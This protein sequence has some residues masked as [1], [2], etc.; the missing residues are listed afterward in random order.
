MCSYCNEDHFYE[1]HTYGACGHSYVICSTCVESGFDLCPKHGRVCPECRGS[2]RG[3]S[4]AP[5]VLCQKE[6]KSSSIGQEILLVQPCAFCLRSFVQRKVLDGDCGH[7]YTICAQCLESEYNGCGT[8]RHHVCATCRGGQ[9][10]HPSVPCRTCGKQQQHQTISIT[11]S[12]DMQVVP[13]ELPVPQLTIQ[14][15]FL[16]PHITG[17][18]ATLSPP[19][20]R[21]GVV[22]WNVAHFSKDPINLYDRYVKARDC[23]QELYDYAVQNLEK[24]RVQA[25]AE[26]REWKLKIELLKPKL[27]SAYETK[28]RV[29]A[30]VKE[31]APPST[32]KGQKDTPEVTRYKKKFAS[33]KKEAKTAK[34]QFNAIGLA[35]IRNWL[36]M[37]ETLSKAQV[38]DQFEFGLVDF[39]HGW[40]PA[41]RT[42]GSARTMFREKRVELA[43]DISELRTPVGRL[44]MT[45]RWREFR[46]CMDTAGRKVEADS[47]FDGRPELLRVKEL[48]ATANAAVEALDRAMHKIM[49]IECIVEMFIANPWLDAIILQEVNDFA[50]FS[51]LLIEY[52]NGKVALEITEGPG[53]KSTSGERNQK[54]TYPIVCRKDGGLRPRVRVTNASV[55]QTGGDMKSGDEVGSGHWNKKVN[56]YRPIVV[57][58]LTIGGD[59]APLK[60]WIGAVHT[61]PAKGAVNTGTGTRQF[62]RAGEFK[63]ID[64]PLAT[65]LEKCQTVPVLVGGDYYLF[66]ESKTI[67]AKGLK[68]SQKTALRKRFFKDREEEKKKY[69]DGNLPDNHPL[70]VNFFEDNQKWY[71]QE[72]LRQRNIIGSATTEDP[73]LPG[74]NVTVGKKLSANGWLVLQSVGGTNFEGTPDEDKGRI[75]DFFLSSD[76]WK[77]QQLG[78]M[79]PS[80]GIIQVDTKS[81]TNAKYWALV[82]DH[83][84]V[85]GCFST[86]T[87]DTWVFEP[88][89]RDKSAERNAMIINAEIEKGIWG[90][91][92][93]FRK[94]K[95]RELWPLSPGDFEPEVSGTFTIDPKWMDK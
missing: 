46:D 18:Q 7:T 40:D 20:V 8:G 37:L 38:W 51:S 81:L 86:R 12:L 87:G 76:H 14:T 79:C 48:A 80:G 42:E 35:G 55:A 84:P 45:L 52:S 15:A 88:L 17:L 22:T 89:K 54:E 10:L 23:C 43:T 33:A 6:F 47:L 61:S 90:G 24:I 60:A 34:D 11:E 85:G 29:L 78:L 72:L 91:K 27:D 36:F 58:E 31:E 50:C 56:S 74:W 62:E 41:P 69:Q 77:S 21:L 30:K 16:N 73:I 57:Y 4:F 92:D 49:V 44:F 28:L 59:E 95:A 25:K 67:T 26:W 32:K 13:F 75:A 82:S 65:I 66:S 70:E 93:K 83:L 19:D 94:G 68:N 2:V 64:A 71:D 9:A 3:I 39:T 1:E 53:L 5:C 63:Q